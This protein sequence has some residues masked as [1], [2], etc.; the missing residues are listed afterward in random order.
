MSKIDP[1]QQN[2]S[3]AVQSLTNTGTGGGTMYYVNLGGIKMLWGI[4]NSISI[5]ANTSASW[6]VNFPSS[7]FTTIQAAVCNTSAL[8]TNVD[9]YANFAATPST[10]AGAGFIQNGGTAAGSAGVSYFI[11]GT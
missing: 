7:F 1:S 3:G 4:T 6:G 5:G 2:N 8:S 11:I 9:Q 10:S